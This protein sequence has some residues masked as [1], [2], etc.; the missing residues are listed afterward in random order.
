[1]VKVA[2]IDHVALGSDFDGVQSTLSDLAT[3]ADL[4]NLTSELMKRGY[5]ATDVQK[6]LGGN[7]LRV[8]EEV[9]K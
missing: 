8:M 9:Q 3:V 6:I 1:V 2:G 7:I 5:T 4:P